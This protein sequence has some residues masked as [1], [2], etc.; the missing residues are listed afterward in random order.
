[1]DRDWGDAAISQEC[2][3]M[4]AAARSERQQGAESCQRHM[5]LTEGELK[6]NKLHSR[7]EG[8]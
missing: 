6:E 2:Q 5:G 3:G 1:M 8:E 7:T 4:A